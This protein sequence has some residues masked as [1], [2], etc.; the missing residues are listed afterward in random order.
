MSE[1]IVVERGISRVRMAELGVSGWP[2]WKDVVGNRTVTLEAT[3]R[4]YFLAGEVV[5]T[6]EGGDPV[7]VGIG[8]LVIIPAGGCRW[9]VKVAVRRD[10]RSDALSPACCII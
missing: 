1:R 10:Y 8:D 9:D 3:E 2:L 6:L 5:L 7:S 4:S